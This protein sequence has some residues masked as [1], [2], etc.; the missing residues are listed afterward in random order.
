M[1]VVTDVVA[2]VTE[3]ALFEIVGYRKVRTKKLVTRVFV[4]SKIFYTECLRGSKMQVGD[5]VIGFP[6]L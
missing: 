5:E 6:D 1:V 3:L 4:N 2:E